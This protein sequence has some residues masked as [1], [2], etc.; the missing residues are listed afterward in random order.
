MEEEISEEIEVVSRREETPASDDIVLVGSAPK[1]MASKRRKRQAAPASKAA[2][3]SARTT[4][5]LRCISVTSMAADAPTAHPKVLEPRSPSIEQEALPE[6]EDEAASISL[7]EEDAVGITSDEPLLPPNEKQGETVASNEAASLSKAYGPSP[8]DNIAQES[9]AAPSEL[10]FSRPTQAP[11]SREKIF[12]VTAIDGGTRKKYLLRE[13]DTL[14]EIHRDFCSKD[15]TCKMRYK[16]FPV[17]RYL[18]LREIGFDKEDTC[19]I[20]QGPRKEEADPSM[21]MLKI[22]ASETTSFDMNVEADA[23]AGELLDRLVKNG[24]S[25]RALIRNGHILNLTKRCR[26]MLAPGDVVDLV[27]EM[28]K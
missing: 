28:W 23:T 11:A 4:S 1:P 14:E 24:H 21:L 16:L 13:S 6:S 7:P 3:R 18:T 10:S 17:S 19:I 22:N 12:K 27:N 8:V 15:R 20:I 2:T 5:I 26:D 9:A 25:G